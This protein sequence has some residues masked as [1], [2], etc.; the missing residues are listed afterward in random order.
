VLTLDGTRATEVTSF[1][2]PYVRGP[3]RDRFAA[4]LVERFGLPERLD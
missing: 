1:V 3:A 2:T 4:D